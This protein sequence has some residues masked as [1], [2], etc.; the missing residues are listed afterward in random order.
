MPIVEFDQVSRIYRSGEHELR[1]LDRVSFT[2]DEGKFVVILGPSGAGKSTLLNLLGGLDS[3]SEGKITVAG[4]D[5]STLNDNELADYRAATVGFVFQFYNL[6][7][8]LTVYENVSLVSEIAPR[9]LD[10]REM[11]AKVGLEDHM[12]NFPA[13][14]SGGEQQRLSIARALAKNPKIL[15]CDEPTGAL[16]SETGVMVLKLLLGMAKEAG[17]TVV[18]VTHNQNIS[19]MADTVIRVKNGKIRSVEEQ[20]NPLSANEVDW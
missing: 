17:K 7:P 11:I 15:L 18:I 5:I 14:L 16:D 13:E 3:P 10:A 1:A 12:H 9:A 2:L 20:A 19:K 8:T 6:I 4:R